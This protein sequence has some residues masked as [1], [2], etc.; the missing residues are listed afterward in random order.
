MNVN[1]NQSVG[2]LPP[3]LDKAGV[4]G[5]T[6]HLDKGL[7]KSGACCEGGGGRPTEICHR[8]HLSDIHF[9]VLNGMTFQVQIGN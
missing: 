8:L 6:T 9:I 4:L 2:T 3:G 5:L 1:S 7:G